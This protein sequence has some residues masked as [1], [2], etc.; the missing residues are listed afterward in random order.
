MDLGSDLLLGLMFLGFGGILWTSVRLALR[1]SKIGLNT[2]SESSAHDPAVSAPQDQAV[3]VV[4]RGGL[5]T[6]INQ[7][8]RILFGLGSEESPD[9]EGL[10]R[11]VRP[12][13][14]F[15]PLCTRPSE[16]QFS[17]S[18]Q[19]V[20][21]NSYQT[22]DGVLV[23][24][25]Q[26]F[27]ETTGDTPGVSSK[28]LTVF[29]ELN[30]AM[31]A[32]VDL[33][34]T[35]EAVLENTSKLVPAD[36][37]EVALWDEQ[38][39]L[40]VPYRLSN[41]GGLIQMVKAEE[42]YR[43]GEGYAGTMIKTH[44]P[45][46]VVD[47][48]AFTQVRL[49]MDRTKFP[50]RAY[51]GFPLMVGSRVI[52]T[53]S[54]GSF[55]REAFQKEDQE[56]VR[57]VCG[58]AAIAIYN[59]LLFQTVQLRSSE[60]SG[61]AKLAQSFSSTRDSGKIYER[62]LSSI[63]PLIPVE[64][65]GFLLYNENTRM[66]EAQKPFMGLPN[67][68]VEIFKAEINSGGTAEGLLLAQ[69]V[70]LTE[71]AVED[72]HWRGLGLDHLARAA[73]MRDT[74]LIP[75][76]SGGHSLGFLMAS[77]HKDG[78]NN[79]S[80]DEM[81]L[82]MIMANQSAPVIENTTLVL[83]SRQ[84]AQRAEA[85]RRI[86]AL[87]S[88]TA[89]L[90]EI[91][92]FSVNELAQLLRADVG[93]VFLLN[94]DHTQLVLH[95]E[96]VFGSKPLA[97][98][99]GRL[100]TEDAQFPF[101][102]AGSQH[103]LVIG[104]FDETV[105][106]V[107]FYQQLLDL[108]DMS[109]AV[110]VPLVVRNEGIG[111][112][113]FGS[114]QSSFYDQGDIQV[115]IPAA[116]QLAGVVEQSNLFSQ[117]DESLRKR[118]DQLT[119]LT[120]ISRELSTTLDLNYLMQIVYDEAVNTTGADSGSILLLD[121]NKSG[122][123]L[124]VRSS[125]GE[126]RPAQFSAQELALFE[127]G[128]TQVYAD[129]TGVQDIVFPAQMCS[130]IIVP[131]LYHQQAA[132][133][134]YLYSR[135][136]NHFDDSAVEIAQSLAAQAAVALGN[137]LQFEKETSRGEILKRELETQEKFF[138]VSGVLRPGQPFEVALDAIAMAIM[139]VTPFDAVLV[140]LYDSALR[141]FRRIVGKGITPELWQE[142]QSR[143]QSWDALQALLKPEFKHG[144]VY[145]IPQEQFPVIPVD[146]HM[147][148]LTQ[149]DAQ[150]QS[151]QW[152]AEDLCLI[153]LF[154]SQGMPL[155]MISVDA[156]Q[157]GLR[158][159]R[160][161]LEALELFATQTGLLMENHQYIYDLREKVNNLQEEH[162]RLRMAA[163]TAQSTLPQ[164]VNRQVQQ[165]E[166][167]ARLSGE[168]DS[169]RTGFDL[170]CEGA[171]HSS[172]QDA[173]SAM[174]GVLMTR[175]GLQTGLVV[176]YLG[177]NHIRL[178]SALG[179]I[180]EGAQVEALLGQK[181]P[182]RAIFQTREW[183]WVTDLA[184]SDEW[185]ASALLRT[186]S[187]TGFFAIPLIISDHRAYGILVMGDHPM[188]QLTEE[189]RLVFN[190]LNQQITRLL[191][192][193]ITLEET[194][195][196]LGEMGQL[197][198]FSRKLA[199]LNPQ[200]ILDILLENSLDVVQPA[201][202]GWVA[203][204]NAK[205]ERLIP[206]AVHG[207]GDK[208]ALL[209]VQFPTSVKNPSL[210]VLVLE[211][212]VARRVDEVNFASAYPLAADDL[213][214]YRQASGGKLPV[215]SLV[216]PLT[217]AESSLGVIVLEN[218]DQE[219]AFE[220]ADETLV[221]SLAQQAA[222]ALENARLFHATEQRTAQLQALTEVGG[223]ITSSLQS[224]ELIAS[225]LDQLR[226]VVNYENATLWLREGDFLSV[227]A[228]NGFSDQESRVGLSA[229]VQDSQLFHQMDAT[230]QA[231]A[232]ADI[233]QDDLF[234]SLM[235][236]ENL[237]WLGIPLVAKGRLIG[238]IALEKKEAGY[239]SHD[240]VQVATT[241][242]SQAAVALENARLFEESMRRTLE[243]DER[244]QRLA[245]LNRFSTDVTATLDAGHILQLTVERMLVAFSCDQAAVI[246]LENE[247]A[248]FY[249]LIPPLQTV[250]PIALDNMALISRLK[251]SMGVYAAFDVYHEVDLTEW[252]T[253]YFQPRST[254]SVLFVPMVSGTMILG[255]VLLESREERRFLPGEVELARTI[256]NQASIAIQNA[257]LLAETRSLT[258]DLEKRVEE[259]TAQMMR[260]HHNAQTLLSIT[261]ELSAS[262]D[263]D[264]VLSR[265]LGVITDSMESY[266]S[267]ILLAM[268]EKLYHAGQRTFT[269]DANG[270]LPLESP[271]KQVGRWVM[272]E[273]GA[274]LVDD[275]ATDLRWEFPDKENLPFRSALVVPL[276][277]GEEILGAL[278]VTHQQPSFY[279]MEQIDL[280][281]AAARQISVALNNA[282]L[283]KLIRDQA[284]NLG[285]ML[286]EQ[287]IESSRSRAI[288]EAV[289]DG[290]LVTDANN[291]ISLFNQSAATILELEAQN[292][293]GNSLQKFSGFFG[294]AAS[295]W[296]ET[297]QYWSADPTAFGMGETYAEQLILD[298]QRVISVH[299]AP[300]V[301]RTDFLGTVSVFRDITVEVQV[302]RLKS[303]FVANVSHELRTPLTAI[304]GYADIMLMGAAGMIS[305]QQK[306]FLEV[307]RTN[308]VRLNILVNDLLDISRIETGRVSLNMQPVEL[309]KLIE[310]IFVQMHTR[311]MEEKKPMH[312][313]MEITGDLLPARGDPERVLQILSNLITNGYNYTPENG[314]LLVQ[315]RRIGPEIQ[316]DVIDNGIG[317]SK[318]DQQRVFERFFRGEDPLV[319]ASSGTGLGLAVAKTLVEMHSGR[320]W[321]TS[322][323]I[324]GEGSVF[325][326][327]LPVYKLED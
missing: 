33:N 116:S 6:T 139:E 12:T 265:T 67:P 32:T 255:W 94:R 181:N 309:P 26:S 189:N 100:L 54:L 57:L 4:G 53:L 48:D 221:S 210:P 82:L 215:S 247:K 277:L 68:F 200:E 135:K 147:V 127:D 126:N 171:R 81:H 193:Q 286:R 302:D 66:L 84:R 155:G 236:P 246:L 264:Q 110:V 179:E 121:M 59:S 22:P 252:V 156:P 153:P 183:I 119:A 56:V 168:L 29:T 324:P 17:V 244:S 104:R 291:K 259:R 145:F 114:R 258:E 300:V 72:E 275:L 120:R 220:A 27:A 268:S 180:P 232:V 223:T 142:L 109:S 281:E 107:P 37:V 167:V 138:Q 42:R 216:V 65:L 282:E 294:A 267:L 45:L 49:G 92:S 161:T 288:L 263:I 102:M 25:R 149:S 51:M 40:L 157:D 231:I 79:F 150:L 148:T 8:A 123:E 20:E 219:A 298:N 129:C 261:T 118:V 159:D 251:E 31:A 190:Q 177:T 308:T 2:H 3:L 237:A 214:R 187:A 131:I 238:L 284:E 305:E 80:Q 101:T 304:K 125:S 74:V 172:S 207:Y 319:L 103:S 191:S 303:E 306:H 76:T 279:M 91:L 39:M 290:V 276:K 50:L 176:E 143:T 224:D 19:W 318:D 213:V 113:W 260:E 240:L 293:V 151:S 162:E 9:L 64:I 1:Q 11:K 192:N 141:G 165:D 88:S 83:Q 21:A 106:I 146:V 61:L 234:P 15:L 169:F 325:S 160:L 285:K 77:N 170:L 115:V 87:A 194:R 173:V 262:L 297:I 28:T 310:G 13:E 280:V 96:S 63:G 41:V 254:Q 327:T 18:G 71:N 211:E 307:I 295:T 44:Q 235:E 122:D 301:W 196:H 316:V 34:Q 182:L 117:T 90:D 222:L 322:S 99:A 278:L 320:I 24:L 198:Q 256:A 133:M 30:Q 134:L 95:E 70:L 204:W 86:A 197:L 249:T 7:T 36:M 257:R 233:R 188:N 23:V 218:Y 269:L 124:V 287:Q 229:A 43:I 208:E 230:H 78:S 164:L 140:S 175:L 105:P 296:L 299:L 315:L 311:S 253:P 217:L 226:S 174:T 186:F 47:V 58:Q 326:F 321:F 313:E 274:T 108:W 130:A 242:A 203:L 52:G 273:R 93:A 73:S 89:T 152:H 271:E 202:A 209:A 212:R 225:L 35:I 289:A 98:Q 314:R 97:G 323:G 292:V 62:M 60:L 132:G 283:F 195:R 38:A 5:V 158:P 10:A 266:S 228:A 75:L 199:S 178:V 69:D 111:E 248:G 112:L 137:A 163:S 128:N 201:H 184:A 206:Q 270:V 144:M 185:Q 16:M 46:W 245:L 55:T 85:L 312:F 272:R 239:Y 14:A 317:I 243:L 250:T 241:F 154:D 205:T 166:K 227:V 136:L